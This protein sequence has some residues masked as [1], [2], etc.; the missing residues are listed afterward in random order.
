MS[1]ITATNK[2][3]SPERTVVLFGAPHTDG[4]TG[5]LL[6]LYLSSCGG[7]VTVIDCFKRAVAPCDDCRGC[8][9]VT[10]C[11]KRDMDDVYEAVEQADRLVLVAP[12]YNRSFP[13]PMKAMLDRFQCYWARRFVHGI[14]PP[15][16]TPKT[17]VL[18][19]VCGSDRED[20]AHLEA[21]VAPLFTVLHV[22]E[23]K[24]LH[25]GGT[26]TAVDWDAVAE[27]L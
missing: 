7:A 6:N 13:A 27:K 17:A 26:D 4:A 9:R 3:L 11:V 16:E 24:V 10:R 18:L 1:A 19:T 5:T 21:Q 8:H 22:T 14:R 15:I 2:P 12:V 25:V 20:G 23:T